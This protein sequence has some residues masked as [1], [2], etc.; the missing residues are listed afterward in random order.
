MLFVYVSEV[1]RCSVSADLITEVQTRCDVNLWTDPESFVQTKITAA[2]GERIMLSCKTTL[3]LPVD[4]Y[5]LP[6]DNKL[7]QSISQA[8]IIVNGYYPRMTLDGSEPG[9]FNLVI[10]N[11]THDDAG[12][13]ICRHEASLGL[14]H[15]MEL[16]VQGK[17]WA[18]V[19]SVYI[20]VHK[21]ILLLFLW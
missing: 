11:V 7:G 21:K 3:P 18:F 20:V 1:W 9:E 12:V 17:G 6:T 4:W 2:V 10:H 8:G 16:I 19:S 13:Y 15:R 5:H 14:E